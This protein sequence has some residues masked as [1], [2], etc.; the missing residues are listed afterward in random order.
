ML[1]GNGKDVPNLGVFDGMLSE[2]E[3]L[4]LRTR[5]YDKFVGE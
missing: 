2:L 3:H 4:A 1:H 5:S